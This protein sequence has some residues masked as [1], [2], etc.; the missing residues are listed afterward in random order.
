MQNFKKYLPALSLLAAAPA[1]A[2][3]DTTW[4]TSAVTAASTDLTAYIA[5]AV[6]L[7]FPIMILVVGVGLVMK[8]V[9]RGA[10]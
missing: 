7:V 8:L 3:T 9:R 2:V 1:F 6:P 5:A 10:K 4:V